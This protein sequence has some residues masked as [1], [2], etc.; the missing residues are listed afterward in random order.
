MKA[1]TG[2]FIPIYK[3]HVNLGIIGDTIQFMQSFLEDFEIL[4]YTKLFTSKDHEF[5]DVSLSQNV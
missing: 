4:N 2:I 1:E 5:R 3:S